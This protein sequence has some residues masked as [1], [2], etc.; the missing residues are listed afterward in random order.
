MAGWLISLWTQAITG[1]PAWK[2]PQRFQRFESY[3]VLALAPAIAVATLA[4]AACDT[5]YVPPPR[6]KDRSMPD[7][8]DVQTRLAFTC[9]YEKDRIPPRD[10]EADQLYAHARWLKKNNLLK[11][12]PSVYPKIERLIRIATAY[13]HDNANLELRQMIGKG[14]AV[15]DDPVKETLDLT[16][17]LIK[18]GIPGGYYDM[19]R[20]LERGYGLKK[21]HDLARKYYRKA[22][23]LGNPEAQYAVGEMLAPIDNAPEIARQMRKCA[24]EQ[25]HGKAASALGIN[26]QDNGHYPEAITAFQLAA[27]GGDSSG[28]SFLS[29]GFK[30][31]PPGDLNYLRLQKDEDR[32][33]RYEAIWS[34]LADY[35]YLN[36]KVPEIDRIVP[37]P[38]AKLP[39]W[40]GK[41]Q[42]LKEHEANVPPPLPSEERIA[43]MARAKGL[44]PATGRPLK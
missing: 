11:E 34:F 16:E 26:L 42:W 15:S 13:G 10:P 41:L 30:A 37:L 18:R 7:L 21:D 35:S 1:L 17:D 24:G 36:P 39:P 22:A 33:R 38:P 3:P 4:L 32:A 5:G 23:D 44:D 12:D 20:Y 14:Q 43:E 9:A 31:P 8:P 40:D 27:K 2:V 6:L 29:E 19:G 28:A 25:G